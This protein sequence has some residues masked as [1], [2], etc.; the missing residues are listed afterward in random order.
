[1]TRREYERHVAWLEAAKDHDIT[2]DAK[3]GAP[4]YAYRRWY[5]LDGGRPQVHESYLEYPK[6]EGK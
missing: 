1:M 3:T 6:L 4:L 5:T 2:I